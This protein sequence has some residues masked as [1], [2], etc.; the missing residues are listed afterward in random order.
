MHSTE[1]SFLNKVNGL[2]GVYEP[3]FKSK[4]TKSVLYSL[5][6]IIL[7]NL[8]YKTNPGFIKIVGFKFVAQLSNFPD[9][10][11]GIRNFFRNKT[12]VLQDCFMYHWASCYTI[13]N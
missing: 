5:C 13:R 9:T 4:C 10:K 3:F 1:H 6:I 7:P 8:A 2:P 12:T 11:F